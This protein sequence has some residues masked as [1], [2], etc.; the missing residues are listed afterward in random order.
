M[1]ECNDKRLYCLLRAVERD[2]LEFRNRTKFRE[3]ELSV[4]HKKSEFI[5]ALIKGIAA[6]SN[7]F[8]SVYCIANKKP[9]CDRK[10]CHDSVKDVTG[11]FLDYNNE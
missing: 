4:L 5:I 2:A 8:K 9:A 6:H 3:V 7:D 10:F 1:N 11:Q